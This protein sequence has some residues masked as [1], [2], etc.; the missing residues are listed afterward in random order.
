MLKKKSERERQEMSPEDKVV[1]CFISHQEAR[2]ILLKRKRDNR[3]IFRMSEGVWGLFY[4]NNDK[5]YSCLCECG[6]ICNQ[7]VFSGA[8]VL[9]STHT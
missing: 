7:T 4:D 9:H 6:F 1:S 2:V 3:V 8:G 5:K